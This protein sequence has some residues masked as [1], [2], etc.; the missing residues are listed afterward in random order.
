MNIEMHV[1]Y[2]L[3]TLHLSAKFGIQVDTPQGSSLALL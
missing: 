2:R 1:G 3:I